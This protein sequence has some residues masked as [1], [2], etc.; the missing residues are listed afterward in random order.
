MEQLLHMLHQAPSLMLLAH[1]IMPFPSLKMSVDVQVHIHQMHKLPL[2]VIRLLH[3]QR[4]PII[5]RML[6]T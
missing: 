1:T 3:P 2:L 4:D 6:E 5:A